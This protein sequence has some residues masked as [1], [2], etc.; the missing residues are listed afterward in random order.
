VTDRKSGWMMGRPRFGGVLY[1][2]FYIHI[3]LA[4]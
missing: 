1:A 3:L 4:T 2:I